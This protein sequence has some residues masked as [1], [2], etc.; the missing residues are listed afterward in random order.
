MCLGA[1]LA[2][3]STDGYRWPRC[4]DPAVIR[5]AV[6]RRQVCVPAGVS[7]SPVLG[8]ARGFP[9]ERREH[10][11]D[12]VGAQLFGEN[13]SGGVFKRWV[14]RISCTF[15]LSFEDYFCSAKG[16]K[17]WQTTAQARIKKNKPQGYGKKLRFYLCYWM[18]PEYSNEGT[19][20]CLIIS[21][22]QVETMPDSR[23]HRYECK[24]WKK[25]LRNKIS[26]KCK[27]N[28]ARSI[29]GDRCFGR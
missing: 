10:R 16:L 25:D 28:P 1:Q 23:V 6:A 17:K 20:A 2:P 22:L 14:F 29:C 9:C 8:K 15:H 4:P 24:S 13:D 3:Q 19:V 18:I 11:Q 26:I 5:R 21:L 12:Q 7:A 27:Q